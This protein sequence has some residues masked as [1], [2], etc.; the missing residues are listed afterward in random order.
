MFFNDHEYIEPNINGAIELKLFDKQKILV[1]NYEY[2]RSNL[3]L[4]IFCG[5][6]WNLHTER[7]YQNF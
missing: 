6:F 1:N 7:C 3:I 2:D 4:K 5:F